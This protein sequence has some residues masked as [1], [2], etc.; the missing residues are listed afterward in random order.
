MSR[1]HGDCTT[2]GAGSDAISS[3]GQNDRYFCVFGRFPNLR[4][5]VGLKL[6]TIARVS[7][8]NL[9]DLFFVPLVISVRE[10]KFSLISLWLVR[11]S[12]RRRAYT[13]S[14]LGES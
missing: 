10:N 14:Q 5:G 8:A 3:A 1:Q 6:C 12:N 11:G 4:S 13:A 7:A 9:R 2:G